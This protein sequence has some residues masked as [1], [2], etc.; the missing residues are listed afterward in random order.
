[1]NYLQKLPAAEYPSYILLLDAPKPP[2][3]WVW[4]NRN[5]KNPPQHDQEYGLRDYKDH[6]PDLCVGRWT[7]ECSGDLETIISKTN[8]II[9]YY[10]AYGMN[11]T[12]EKINLLHLCCTP[13]ILR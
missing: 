12:E 11:T 8:E 1:M 3:S 10:R 5:A 2:L 9:K 6:Y 7:V 4:S 13:S